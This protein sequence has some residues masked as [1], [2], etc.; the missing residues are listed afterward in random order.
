MSLNLAHADTGSPPDVG[1]S[2]NRNMLSARKPPDGSAKE[3]FLSLQREVQKESN[4][5]V[6]L[7]IIEEEVD[8]INAVRETTTIVR[9]AMDLGL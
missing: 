4:E 7:M 5:V 3:I 6:S 2:S 1:L 8:A 9:V